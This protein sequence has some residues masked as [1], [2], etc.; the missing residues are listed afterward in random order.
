M[1]S[2]K[3]RARLAALVAC[4]ALVATACGSSDDDSSS[5]AAPAGTTAATAAAGS[6]DT[7][8]AGTEASGE[9]DVAAGLVGT[10][11]QWTD[12][13]AVCGDEP[14]SV[15]LVDGYGTN[16]WSKTVLAELQAE[17]EKCSSITGVEF[18]AGRGDLA[19]TT[20]AITSMAAKGVQLILAI[21]DAGPGEAHLPA[22]RT[23]TEAGSI[24]VNVASDPGGERGTDYLDYVDWSPQAGGRAWAQWTVDQLGPDGGNIVFIGG[25][26][27][28]A[29][30]TQEFEGV[31]EVLADHPNVTL[32]VDEPVVTN[33]DPAQAQEAMAGLL[34]KYDDIDAL[35]VDYGATAGGVIRAYEAA[36]VPLPP[37]TTTDDNSLSCG[38]ADLSAKNPD[39]QLSTLSSRT[40]AVRVAL[41]KGLAAYYGLSNTEP[42][43]YELALF[44][45]STGAAAGAMAPSEACL[46]DAPAD[47]TPSSL[48]TAEQLAAVFAG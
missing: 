43:I 28:S 26:A 14:L 23:A 45:D 33:W 3:S 15:G 12:I 1:S 2:T 35:I 25:P 20:S 27:G 21:P 38:F 48:L 29:V 39:Y 5:T 19:A 34:A 4:G 32:L 7:A 13:S 9:P 22:L 11:D 42:S 8:A 17:A 37:I 18:V 31:K 30:S 44:E 41:R 6:G 47:A 36:G 46:A 40:W 16:A 24:V 10:V